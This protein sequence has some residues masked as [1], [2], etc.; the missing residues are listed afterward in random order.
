MTRPD[1]SIFQSHTSK[2]VC[3]GIFP[4][5]P[6]S[7]STI[8]TGVHPNNGNS[9]RFRHLKKSVYIYSRIPCLRSC[10]HRAAVCCSAEGHLL[11]SVCPAP[12]RRVCVLND[13]LFSPALLLRDQP[14]PPTSVY[15]WDQGGALIEGVDEATV[16]LLDEHKLSIKALGDRYCTSLDARR[17][18]QSR[19][20]EQERATQVLSRAAVYTVLPSLRARYLTPWVETRAMNLSLVVV[21]IVVFLFRHR[22]VGSLLSIASFVSRGSRRNML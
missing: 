1:E 16:G 12:P 11:F 19:G 18:E 13:V 9:S 2:Q 6:Q 5:A 15:K 21:V 17:P 22:R 10:A 3:C 7:S 8:R 20:L 4:P 14:N